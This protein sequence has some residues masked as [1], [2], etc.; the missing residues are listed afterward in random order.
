MITVSSEFT[1]CSFIKNISSGEFSG[2]VD[3]SVEVHVHTENECRETQAPLQ[4]YST[5]VETVGS[6][7]TNL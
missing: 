7:G 1:L 6:A 5:L 2:S 3:T 4:G